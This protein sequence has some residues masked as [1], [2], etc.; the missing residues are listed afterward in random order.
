MPTTTALAPAVS[1]N[2]LNDGDAYFG[3]VTIDGEPLDIYLAYDGNPLSEDDHVDEIAVDGDGNLLHG[4]D[5][6]GA[7]PAALLDLIVGLIE[8]GIGHRVEC[9]EG[10]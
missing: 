6:R 8:Q 10:R 9:S 3:Q 2:P 5:H 7:T 4:F 1:F